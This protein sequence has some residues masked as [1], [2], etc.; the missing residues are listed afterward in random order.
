MAFD[1][2]NVML[3][4]FVKHYTQDIAV[5]MVALFNG[6]RTDEAKALEAIH[7]YGIGESLDVVI[8]TKRQYENV[9]LTDTRDFKKE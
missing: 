1:I 9:F 3:I 2:D 7:T 8:I 5:P 4:E 6:R